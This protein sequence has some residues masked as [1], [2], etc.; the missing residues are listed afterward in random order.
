MG[1]RGFFPTNPG[2][3]DILDDTDFDFENFYIFFDPNFQDL[4]VADFQSLCATL[5]VEFC[6]HPAKQLLRADD[7][8]LLATTSQLW[9][10]VT[11]LSLVDF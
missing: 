7:A 5:Q 8:T 2:L 9:I 3:A 11:R 1:P 4:Q 6:I 10:L